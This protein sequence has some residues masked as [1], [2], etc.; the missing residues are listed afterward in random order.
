MTIGERLLSLT[1]E[2][3]NAMDGERNDDGTP[4]HGRTVAEIAND[5]EAGLREL[6]A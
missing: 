6:L 3:R 4:V 1:V 5:Y 2:Y